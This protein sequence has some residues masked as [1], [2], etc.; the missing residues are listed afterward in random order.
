ICQFEDNYQDNIP[1]YIYNMDPDDY[2]EIILCHETPICGP[3]SARLT[4]WQA[5]SAQFELNPQSSYAKLHF[6]RP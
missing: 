5:I 3:L 4:D 6:F 2:C 1:N